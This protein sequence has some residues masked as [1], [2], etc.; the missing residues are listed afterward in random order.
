MEPTVI[1]VIGT[2]YLGEYEVFKS[3]MFKL[4]AN[5]RVGKKYKEVE[6]ISSSLQPL[7][8]FPIMWA[9]RR[10][11]YGGNS[12][13]VKE[14]LGKAD[15]IIAFWDTRC[16]VVADVVLQARLKGI[17]VKLIKH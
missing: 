1:A 5:F 7:D 8:I 10:R 6:V 16:E 13:T 2:R 15:Y 14:L 12:A 4:L 11:I 9:K 17:K 3:H